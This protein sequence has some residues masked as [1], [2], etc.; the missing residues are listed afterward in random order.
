MVM[1]NVV[2]LKREWWRGSG[3][4]N[5][6]ASAEAIE[7]VLCDMLG[8][9]VELKNNQLALSAEGGKCSYHFEEEIYTTF[10]EDS[11]IA[12]AESECFV[13]YKFN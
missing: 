10:A 2:L 3:E 1:L 12:N 11:V 13:K 9:N 5:P 8:G 6:P 4:F 7:D